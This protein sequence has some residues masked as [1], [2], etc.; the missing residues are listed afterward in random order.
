[1]DIR[2]PFF[3]TL[4]LLVVL[5]S[6]SNSE[7]NAQNRPSLVQ[8]KA[9]CETKLCFA[10]DGS[11]SIS[12]LFELQQ[13]FV[14]SLVRAIHSTVKPLQLAAVQYGV[15]NQPI[16]PLT[17]DTAKFVKLVNQT[18]FNK[19]SSTFIRGGIVYC[20]FELTSTGPEVGTIIVLGD[21]RGNFGGDP[22]R[23]ANIFRKIRGRVAAVGVGNIDK[24]SLEEIVGGDSSLVFKLLRSNLLDEVVCAILDR[25]CPSAS[26]CD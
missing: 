21:G 15:D 6:V 22:V 25:I 14:I 5:F 24:A 9:S 11:G 4:A 16:S 12:G 2:T 7:Q 3:T 8:R 10:L 18:S 17:N 13:S 26:L 19:S 23:S 1:M 20:D